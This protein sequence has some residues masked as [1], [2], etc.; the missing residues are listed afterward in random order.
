MPKLKTRKTLT[1]RVK[2]TKTNRLLKRANNMGHL[3][4]KFDQSKKSRKR[5]LQE[6]TSLKYKILFR[7]LLGI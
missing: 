5:G 4:V 3:K 1:K 7:R 2:V 6:I